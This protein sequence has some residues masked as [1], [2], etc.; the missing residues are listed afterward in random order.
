MFDLWLLIKFLVQMGLCIRYIVIVIMYLISKLK[1][2]PMQIV[3]P[4]TFI[5]FNWSIITLRTL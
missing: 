2:R 4:L 1:Y 3:L 5:Y